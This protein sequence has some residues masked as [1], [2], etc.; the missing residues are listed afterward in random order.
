MDKCQILN[1]NLIKDKWDSGE[2]N[3]TVYQCK[4]GMLFWKEAFLLLNT[5]VI[6]DLSMEKQHDNTVHF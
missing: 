5:L 3:W 1:A 4:D 6:C 2:P